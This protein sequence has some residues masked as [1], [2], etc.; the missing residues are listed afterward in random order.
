MQ[1][2]MVCGTY[3][4]RN[5]LNVCNMFVRLNHCKMNRMHMCT[6]N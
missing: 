6:T 5:G 1:N 3:Y 2:E 4:Q